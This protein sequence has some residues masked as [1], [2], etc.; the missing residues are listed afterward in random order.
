VSLGERRA[1]RRFALLFGACACLTGAVAG[2][3]AGAASLAAR[4]DTGRLVRLERPARRIVSLAPSTTELL[5]AAG[6]GRRLVGAVDYSN[7]PPAAKRVPRVGGAGSLDL[8]A[9]VAR[10]P[11]L[12]LAWAGGNARDQVARLSALNIPVF[13]IDPQRLDDIPSVIERLGE[14]AGTAP[15]ARRAAAR[16]RAR[17]DALRQRYAGRGKVRVFYQIWDRPLMTVNG[18]QMISDVLRLCGGVNVFAD[19]PAVAGT[20]SREAVLAAD[21]QVII[22][23]GAGARR[24]QWLAAWR[25]W[26]QLSAVKL[27]QLYV[28]PPDIIQRQGPRILDG[29]ALV[30][31]DLQRARRALAGQR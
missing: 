15:A 25:Q 1:A 13:W 27:G 2:T 4:D 19:L 10:Q 6:A 18:R 21:P 28:V 16:W 20:V 8:E 9:I 24:P 31:R 11:D 23:S 14:L 26:P 29:A 12:V 22:V 7:Y 5:Y 3:V 17:L 30:C